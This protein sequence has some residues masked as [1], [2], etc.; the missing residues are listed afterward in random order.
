ME[1]WNP[2]GLRDP[3]YETAARQFEALRVRWLLKELGLG[4]LH[5]KVRRQEQSFSGDQNLTFRAFNT[6]CSNFPLYL[7]THWLHR[8][9]SNPDCRVSAL[10]RQF[11][12]SPFLWKYSDFLAALRGQDARR[13]VRKRPIGLI[14]PWRNVQ[15]GLLIHNAEQL[16]TPGLRWSI[17]LS[18]RRGG[19]KLFVEP[20]RRV[21]KAILESGWQVDDLFYS[22]DS[23]EEADEE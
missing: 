14:V 8:L 5:S 12:K 1:E 13:L 9:E 20:F 3:W 18:P 19:G 11:E 4:H 2:S 6:C 16:D 22:G 10:F 15:Q 7:G 17:V 21:V 23:D